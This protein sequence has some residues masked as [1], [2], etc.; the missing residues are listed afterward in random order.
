MTYFKL[1]LDE[2]EMS[3]LTYL[4]PEESML[5][6][7]PA[8]TSEVYYGV[9]EDGWYGEMIKNLPRQILNS[10]DVI[11]IQEFTSFMQVSNNRAD[12]RRF[13]GNINLMQVR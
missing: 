7:K 1:E 12:E 4:I 5:L 8:E 3:N 11:T 13:T 9:I 10:L 6:I 2:Q